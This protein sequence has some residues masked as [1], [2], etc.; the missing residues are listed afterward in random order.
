MGASEAVWFHIKDIEAL[1]VWSN[2]RFHVQAAAEQ[3]P[4][5][6]APRN[7]SLDG[8]GVFIHDNVMNNPG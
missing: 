4:R 3:I 1:E 8:V 5:R 6:C 2:E 7:D